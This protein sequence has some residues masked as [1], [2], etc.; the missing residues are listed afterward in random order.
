[1]KR[2]FR[3][4]SLALL[5][6]SAGP[7]YAQNITATMT[8]LVTDAS[9]SIIPGAYVALSHELSR[10]DRKA[11]TNSAGYYK[12]AA[13]PAVR[14]TLGVASGLQK[15][16][17]RGIKV[18]GSERVMAEATEATTMARHAI[19]LQIGNDVS[20]PG[21]SAAIARLNS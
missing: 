3:R 7:C 21:G 14:Y 12:V 5:L 15:H 19:L 4:T 8:G 6:G 18:N 9:G 13:I 2:L 17:R 20:I 10:N 16:A 1:M 11:V